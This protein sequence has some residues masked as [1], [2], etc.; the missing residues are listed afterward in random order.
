MTVAGT[1][2][3]VVGQPRAVVAQGDLGAV[4]VLRLHAGQRQR[5]HAVPLLPRRGPGR[6]WTR[7][8]EPETGNQDDIHDP[9]LGPATG[10]A[11]LGIATRRDQSGLV[12]VDHRLGP[13]PSPSLVKT[14]ATW[15]LTVLSPTNRR[16]A[17]SALDRPRTSRV[18]T[19]RSRSVS[20]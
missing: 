2:S 5:P 9:G 12:A 1:H 16:P 13:V 11:A 20:R 3:D 18:S 6:R 14:L 7:G 15:V 10:S 8:V 19:S 17:I 4:G